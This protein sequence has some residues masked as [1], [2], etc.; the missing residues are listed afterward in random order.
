[1]LPRYLQ[2]VLPR[3]LQRVLPR[4]L[5]RVLP[6]YLQR[7]LP[8]YLQRVLPRYLAPPLSLGSAPRSHGGVVRAMAL[9]SGC[10]R[11]DGR[12]PEAGSDVHE[13]A[14]TVDTIRSVLLGHIQ[15]A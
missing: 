3:Y 14:V 1:V 11:I 7:V 9:L 12:P 6:R 13:G 10:N 15:S 8:R 2:R 5:Q 4:Y